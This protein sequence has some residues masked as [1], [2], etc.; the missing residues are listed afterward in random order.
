M[1]SLTRVNANQAS[2]YYTADDYYL[3]SAGHW[4]GEL[5]TALGYTGSIQEKDF[6]SLI[7]G[8]D[9]RDNPRFE[10]QSGGKD[11][12]HTAGVDLTFSAPKSVS[13]A[14]L[15][16]DDRRVIE[17]HGKAV[18][19]TLNYIEKNYTRVRIH[20][21]NQVYTESTGN[22]LAAKFQHISSRELDP[23]LHTHCLVMNFT[24]K[25]NGDI[26]AMDYGDIYNAKMLLG[27]MY[28]SELAANLKDIGYA[29]ESDSK[30]LFEIKGVP[31]NLIKEFS[32]RSEQI[33]QR[34]EEL[35]EQFPTAN[36]A[37]LKSIA[38]LD[39][40]KVK[41]EP[42][43]EELKQ[44]W[45]ERA[46]QLSVNKDLLTSKLSSG[47]ELT[48]SV[49][50]I[51]SVI[52]RAVHIA[53]EHEAVAKRDDILRVA[54]KITMGEHRIH[55]LKDALD[56][57][58]NIIRLEDKSYTT[59]EIAELEH[60]LVEQVVSGKDT[61]TGL[62]KAEIS[63]GILNYQMDKGF[64]LTEGQRDAVLHVLGSTDRIIAIQGDAGTGKTTMLDVVRDIAEQQKIEVTGL[65]F[66][67][68]AAS[69]IEEASSIQ[70]RTISS[71]V[72]STDDL[73]GKLVVID[74]ASMLSIKDMNRLM[75]KCDE[76]TK[77]VLI[78][79]TKQLQTIGQGKIFS[80]LQEKEVISTVRMSEVQRQKD[81]D[82]KDVVDKLGDKQIDAAFNKLEA[83]S[84]INEIADR[85]ERLS[86]VTKTY[87][88]KPTDSIIVTATNKDREELNR[89]IRQELVKNGA[90]KGEAIDYVTRETKSLMGEEKFFAENYAVKDIIVANTAGIIGKAGAEAR[91]AAVDKEQ[92]TV[93][94][95]ADG[96]VFNIALN[97]H[98]NNLQ[99]Y[100]EKSRT[101]AEGDRILFLKNDK[102]LEV[103]N[104]QTGYITCIKENGRISVKMDNGKAVHFNPD[105]QYKYISHG[106]ALT[107]YKSQGQTEKHV[108]YHAD[109]TKGVN[110]N[111][112]YVGITRGKD[113]V[114]I[115]TNDKEILRQMVKVEQHK[116][117][118]L[119]HNLH[120][121]KAANKVKLAGLASRVPNIIEKLHEQAPGADKANREK[122]PTKTEA[123]S[124]KNKI[125]EQSNSIK[126][127]VVKKDLDRGFDR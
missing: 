67:G 127:Q 71:L 83:K 77:V 108:I 80:S 107:D 105:K 53:T 75:G 89:M 41:D 23:Q 44:Q 18:S 112:A 11:N 33:Q 72:N 116:T 121:A 40:R 22:L 19:E 38:T 104:G 59:F 122:D 94:V 98:G 13:I 36:D 45:N 60:K 101:F 49:K 118:T 126:D 85:N 32:T 26:K 78:G 124:D 110:Y 79:D 81:V 50:D 103:K 46:N 56:K 43:V 27:Q 90:V 47:N 123:V 25:E 114:K 92:N 86:A 31:D 9:N 69:E 8:V 3:E 39:T 29:I 14:G 84:L 66:T 91:I 62:D 12:I 21:G 70:S 42:S 6:Q 63:Q 1:L 120:E 16:L 111:Q 4:Q 95:K 88:E 28:R 35:K 2:S 106:Y 119:D 17:A 5:A 109:T 20:E 52:E 55:E 7:N 10:I 68:K 34:F 24:A 76:T 57:N 64:N 93:M 99:V 61:Q 58:E 37:E 125:N 102:G 15:I 54:A 115:Y 117:T 100:S 51:N 96:K 97:E 74:E 73:K 82:Y 48:E 113:S 30:G 65:S 87:L